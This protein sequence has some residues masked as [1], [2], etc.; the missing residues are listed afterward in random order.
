MSETTPTLLT[1]PQIAALTQTKSSFWYERSRRDQIPGL[2]RIGKFVRVDRERF[3]EALR[4]QA[5][6]SK[7]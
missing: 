3:Y 6:E 4:E 1:I 7:P 5:E 2:V